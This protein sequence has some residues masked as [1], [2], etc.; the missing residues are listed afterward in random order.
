M[1]LADW[2]FTDIRLSLATCCRYAVNFRYVRMQNIRKA[3]IFLEPAHGKSSLA[4]AIAIEGAANGATVE[5]LDGT[6]GLTL[7]ELNA[8]QQ[9]TDVLV[10]V[11][12]VPDAS[13]ARTALLERVNSLKGGAILFAR[14]DYSN[15]A[16]LKPDVPTVRVAHIDQRQIDK[17]A[18]L[19]GLIREHL[20]D[21]RGQIPQAFS[22]ALKKIPVGAFMALCGVALGPKVADLTLLARKVAQAVELG[23]GLGTE[24]A[25]TEEE[26]ATIFVEFHS[27]GVF[28]AEH[29]FRLWVE[30]ESDSRLLKLVCRLALS[31]HAVDLQEGLSIIPL[32]EGRD[33]GTSKA[34]EVVV[35]RRT[36]RNKDIFLFDADEPGRHA[37]AEL[38]VLDQEVLSWIRKL[39]AVGWRW[40]SRSR[41][42]SASAV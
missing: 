14:P 10:I 2:S 3:Y 7:K 5:R 21:E 27:Q 13:P 25:L 18:W 15:D 19:V 31:V 17:V 42:L 29:G 30:G 35:N 11:D 4:K 23:V 38:D 6:S 39:R 8:L 41:I 28:Q 32:G 1:S 37:K 20:R 26:L 36:R 9:K 33:G 24:T 34:M 22:D 12:G 40:T 16:N